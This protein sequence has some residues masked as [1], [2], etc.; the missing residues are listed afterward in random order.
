MITLITGTPGAGKTAW[1]V[2]EITRLPS[3]RKIYVHGIPGLKVPHDV[4]FCRSPLCDLCRNSPDDNKE[5]YLE[6]WSTW[7]T[8]GSLIIADEVQRIWGV[9]NA[10]ATK[11]EDISRLQTH[12][13]I[14]LDFWLISQSPKLLNTGVRTLVGRHIHL[15]SKWS[16]RSEYEYPEVKDDTSS[17]GDAVVRPY[18]LPSQIFKLYHSSSLHTK[19]KHR[20]PLALYAFIA[21]ISICLLLGVRLYNRFNGHTELHETTTGQTTK[22]VQQQQ[23]A[24]VETKKSIYPDFKP[25]I[26]NIPAS[27]PAYAG[28]NEV[29]SVPHLIGCVR[30]PDFC[31]CYTKQAVA[32]EVT[33]NFCSE[34]IAGRVF[35]PFREASNKPESLANSS[36]TP[37]HSKNKDIKSSS[38]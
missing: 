23:I 10:G 28:L 6:D 15:V 3:Q 9:T 19:L 18:K 26:P 35:N 33:Y 31:R 7:A 21:V 34:F 38:D 22:P 4:I 11:T 24:P 36:Y 8:P 27:A 2:Q 13:H 30:T 12:R 5:Y 14:G 29:K 32:V 20:K 37:Y 16:G 17:K 1:T 25:T